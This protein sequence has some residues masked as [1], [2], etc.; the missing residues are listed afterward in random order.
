MHIVITVVL[1]LNW[2][3]L[4]SHGSTRYNAVS[5]LHLTIDGIS[6]AMKY[7]ILKKKT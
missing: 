4:F 5:S 6:D 2:Q 7:S 1:W 3:I